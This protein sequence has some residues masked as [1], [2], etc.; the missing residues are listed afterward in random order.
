M[1]EE[2]RKQGE[3]WQNESS[4]WDTAR[5]N[6]DE[7]IDSLLGLESISKK[8]KEYDLSNPTLPRCKE[9]VRFR[10]ESEISMF[11]SDCDVSD[12]NS[13][14]LPQLHNAPQP[15]DK[16]QS[17]WCAIERGNTTEWW[18]SEPNVGR[19]AYGVANR[20]DRLKAIGNGQVPQVAALAWQILMDRLH[21]NS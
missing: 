3:N 7:R 19:V 4:A 13:Q 11:G 14:R 21:E 6:N 9:D 17:T 18:A 15:V 12:T 5:A 16:G 2:A 8:S 10:N 20:V 1:G